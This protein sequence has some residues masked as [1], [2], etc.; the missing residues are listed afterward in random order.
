[1]TITGNISDSA[2]A[3]D[4][5]AKLRQR[6]LETNLRKERTQAQINAQTEELQRMF[7][8][9]PKKHRDSLD[10]MD[11]KIID[12]EKKRTGSSLILSEEKKILRQID[13]IEKAKIQLGEYNK[14]E[15]SIQEKKNEI[16][17]LRDSLRTDIAAIAELNSALSKLELANRLGCTTSE[18]QTCVVDCPEGKLGFVIGKSGATI[19]HIEQRTGVR[20]DI[21]KL[22]SKIHL[23]G[24]KS[25][26]EE[27]VKEVEK[28]TL[29]ITE[30]VSISPDVVTYL[31][32][33]VSEKLHITCFLLLPCFLVH[34]EILFPC[35][36]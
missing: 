11:A 16:S 6:L 33:K 17:V 13:I 31:L 32:A 8:H 5:N 20:I 14:H 23:Q 3:F 22:G 30:D 28:I 4:L 27:A 10:S 12:L 21:D 9:K 35:Y 2:E 34:F 18:L 25:V 19:K 36:S 7:M 1:M 29:A 15:R 24:S 26:L